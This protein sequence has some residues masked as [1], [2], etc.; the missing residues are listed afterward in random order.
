MVKNRSGRGQIDPGRR[1]ALLTAEAFVITHIFE[2][3]VLTKADVFLK[4]ANGSNPGGVAC[5]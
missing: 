5:L 3:E 4:L 1:L 2:K